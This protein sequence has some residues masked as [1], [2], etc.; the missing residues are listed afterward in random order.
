MKQLTG[1]VPPRFSR[2]IVSVLLTAI[3]TGSFLVSSLVAF[4]PDDPVVRGMADKGV[5]FLR[6]YKR[7]PKGGDHLGHI[8]GR[9]LRA[10]AI[11]KYMDV[12]SIPGAKNDPLVVAALSEAKE[13]GNNK[14]LMAEENACYDL[15]VVMIFLLEVDASQYR[16]QTQNM[17]DELMRRQMKNGAW[18]YH[19]QEGLHGDTSQTQY[20]VLGLW[21][22]EKQGLI[23]DSERVADACNWLLRTQDI[24]GSWGYHGEDPGPGNFNRVDQINKPGTVKSNFKDAQSDAACGLSSLY[25]TAGMLQFVKNKPPKKAAPKE[26]IAGGAITRKEDPE[27]NQGLKPLTRSVSGGILSQG[28]GDGDG[29]FQ[30]NNSI[31]SEGTDWIT[32]ASPRNKVVRWPYY[33]IYVY[34][35]YN[36]FKDLAA[37]QDEK[38]PNWYNR[39]VV[40]LRENQK[41]DGS[42]DMGKGGPAANTSFSVFFLIRSTRKSVQNFA[43]DTTFRGGKELPGNVA[44]AR[45][46]DGKVLGNQVSGDI[47]AILAM[48]DDPDGIDFSAAELPPE[49]QLDPDAKKRKA[50][51]EKLKALVSQ[52]SYKARRI[53]VRNLAR[54]EGL[55]AVP[56]L[57]YALTDKDEMVMREARDALRFL[58]RRL[59]G[60]GL[61]NKPTAEEKT[62]AYDKWLQWFRTV[63]P[64]LDLDEVIISPGS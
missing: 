44:N 46:E 33:F 63:R 26:N 1:I 35:R 18:S 45:Y 2:T 24:G 60:F 28:L 51:V 10:L 34:E 41:A 23:V 59:D 58:S 11:Y 12:Y 32:Q 40:F 3:F 9:V 22:A 31:K 55:D 43:Q 8:G 29:W 6:S 19:G 14:Q 37:G 61:R 64:D 5:S 49:L 42:W 17:L 57:L 21:T 20:V 7:N 48:L 47:D 27:E 53:A 15:A 16:V 13:W 30:A 62:Q 38:S 50:Q 39:G 25:I 54:A 4:D 52:G 36:T 56:L